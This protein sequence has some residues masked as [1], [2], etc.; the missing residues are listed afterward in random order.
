MSTPYA[1]APDAPEGP[2]FASLLKGTK[3]TIPGSSHPDRV[4]EKVATDLNLN[5][6]AGAQLV[7]VTAETITRPI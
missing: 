1:L 5:A 6:Q 4:Y 7:T 2:T 3:F